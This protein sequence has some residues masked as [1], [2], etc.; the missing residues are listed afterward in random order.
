MNIANA[1]YILK[2]FLFFFFFFNFM[3][4][5][6]WYIYSVHEV[7]CTGISDETLKDVEIKS[8]GFVL[9]FFIWILS[10]SFITNNT[11]LLDLL[12]SLQN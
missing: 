8:N 6:S 5:G 12:L 9:I 1:I 3:K 11:N 10:L 2:G 4:T 7:K